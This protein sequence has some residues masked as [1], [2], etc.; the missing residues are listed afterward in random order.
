MYGATVRHVSVEHRVTTVTATSV[1]G[2]VLVNLPVPIP[3]SQETTVTNEFAKW[4]YPRLN[5]APGVLAEDFWPDADLKLSVRGGNSTL[6]KAAQGG[7]SV[8]SKTYP[9]FLYIDMWK[10]FFKF[11]S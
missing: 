9:C 7:H 1:A 10:F 3:G 6:E 2:Q 8:V 5:Q 11:T 4:F